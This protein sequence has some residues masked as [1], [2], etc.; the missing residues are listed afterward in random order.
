MIMNAVALL[1]ENPHPNRDQIIEK[2][3]GNI[4][5]CNNYSRIITAILEVA[6]K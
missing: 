5:R 4:C 2:M 1:K 3:N 6:G